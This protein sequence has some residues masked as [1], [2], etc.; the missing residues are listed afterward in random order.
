[1]EKKS[2]ME[3]ES[4]FSWNFIAIIFY[5]YLYRGLQ[6]INSYT[7]R[8]MTFSQREQFNKIYKGTNEVIKDLCR[9]GDYQD[10]FLKHSGEFWREKFSK[11]ENQ[12]LNHNFISNS[13]PA[14]SETTT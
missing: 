5:R 12:Y 13:L 10:E 2:L 6:C 7:R 8:C 11:S 3:F 14:K 1:M 9:K 4:I